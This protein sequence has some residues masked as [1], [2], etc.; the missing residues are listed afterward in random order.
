MVVMGVHPHTTLSQQA[1]RLGE[2]LVL[3]PQ[4]LPFL[5]FGVRQRACVSR[6][7]MLMGRWTSLSGMAYSLSDVA[8]SLRDVAHWGADTVC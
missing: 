1:G 3:R 2:G 7:C 5:V 4:L 8:H 6:Y